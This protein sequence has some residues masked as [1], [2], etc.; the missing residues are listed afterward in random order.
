MYKDADVRLLPL[1]WTD[2]AWKPE[3]TLTRSMLVLDHSSLLYRDKR[4]K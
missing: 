2:C 1:I 4:R 3:V